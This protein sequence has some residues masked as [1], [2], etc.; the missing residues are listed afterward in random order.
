MNLFQSFRNKTCRK[1]F[2]LGIINTDVPKLSPGAQ[3]TTLEGF[4]AVVNHFAPKM[5]F[6]LPWNVVK[7][8]NFEKN[9]I[10]LRK[11][12]FISFTLISYIFD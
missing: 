3:T 8:N 12:I 2:G 6:F 11:L 4:H 5:N 10:E 1:I 9:N 7:L